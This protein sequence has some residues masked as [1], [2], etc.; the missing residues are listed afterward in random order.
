MSLEDL[1]EGIS[2]LLHGQVMQRLL[3][4]NHLLKSGMKFRQRMR[5]P[6]V[7]HYVLSG[8]SLSLFKLGRSSS[9]SASSNM[10]TD[11]AYR[12]LSRA[13]EVRFGLYSSG[14][15]EFSIAR[16]QVFFVFASTCAAIA[17]S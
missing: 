17:F 11:C 15:D 9:N 16:C 13:G 1:E 14:Y 10:D 5:Y 3:V 2:V 6:E 4:F 12:A 8:S 7:T